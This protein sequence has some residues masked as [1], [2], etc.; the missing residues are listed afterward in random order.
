VISSATSDFNS[1]LVENSLA[2]FAI[3]RCALTIYSCHSVGEPIFGGATLSLIARCAFACRPEID[4][5]GHIA[6]LNFAVLN[7]G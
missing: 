5:F 7:V 4:N 6:V 2:A 3:G 1:V